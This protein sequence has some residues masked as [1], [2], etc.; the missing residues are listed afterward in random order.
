[1]SI[2]SASAAL[3]VFLPAA[4]GTWIVPPDFRRGSNRL[5]DLQAR[6][7]GCCRWGPYVADSPPCAIFGD[8]VNQVMLAPQRLQIPFR[9]MRHGA[10]DLAE[11][12]VTIVD[13]P[14]GVCL[15]DLTHDL[16]W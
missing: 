5:H 10:H 7:N 12:N 13:E 1:M 15:S 16:A 2:P 6:R 4:A 14:V 9:A 8:V 11:R 3:L